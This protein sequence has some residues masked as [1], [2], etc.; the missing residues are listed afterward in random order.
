MKAPFN[1]LITSNKFYQIIGI[2]FLVYSTIFIILNLNFPFV[3]YDSGYYLAVAR[4]VYSGKTYFTDIAVPYT[5]LSILSLG[6]PFLF[7]NYLNLSHHLAI[8]YLIL[9]TCSIIL[10]S[11]VNKTLENK[12]ISFLLSCFFLAV[13]L[14][15]D[16]EHLMLE[17][18]SIFFQL[19][20]LKLIYKN[21]KNLP[22]H[23][24]L[25]G[26]C[27]SLSFLAKQLGLFIILPILIYILYCEK[28][29][30]K[31]LLYIVLGISLPII[32]L[33]I[34][35]SLHESLN[36]EQFIL[37]II[38]KGVEFE[39]GVGTGVNDHFGFKVYKNFVFLNLYVIL[40]PFLIK[41]VSNKTNDSK[42]SL[43]FYI[44]LPF[45]SFSVL[46]IAA[47]N[48]YFQFI[49]PY[50]IICFAYLFS[51]SKDKRLKY[52]FSILILI[53]LGRLIDKSD[54][55][56]LNAEKKHLNQLNDI[57]TLKKLI[58]NEA[59]VYLEEGVSKAYYGTNEFQS[60]NSKLIGYTFPG[61][62]S[63][64]TIYNNLDDG[65]FLILSSKSKSKYLHYITNEE[66]I[67]TH[68]NS[69]DIYIYK[70]NK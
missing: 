30:L 10:F 16:G 40:I 35:Y 5:P 59:K 15:H 25:S 8:N 68:I 69:R 66:L 50:L 62:F 14:Y 64:K 58:P 24:I 42:F 6:I 23:F 67:K 44:S 37:H 1:S 60:I 54:S 38:G 32:S 12:S 47:Y 61:Y 63:P 19:L 65:A 53:S 52:F 11:I 29:I 51:L 46:L 49:I 21:K 43:L 4:D 26:V 45:A 48:H 2:V 33:Y 22:I 28:S 56:F 34:F 20:S 9:I 41:N 36:L 27:I 7:E 55:N 3:G 31:K 13:C 39:T 18:I 70:K 17:P 57:N